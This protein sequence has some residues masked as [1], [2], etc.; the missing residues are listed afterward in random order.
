MH[1]V[2]IGSRLLFSRTLCV[3][4]GLFG[5][6]APQV[7]ADEVAIHKAI[8]A[9]FATEDLD[10]RERLVAQI[11]SDPD[12]DPANVSAYLHGAGL[13]KPLETGRHPLT[14][15]W[16]DRTTALVLRIPANYDPD[17]AY[18]LLY[19]LHGAGGTADWI[20]RYFEFVL[21]AQ[22]E[23]FVVAAPDGYQQTSFRMNRGVLPEHR[24]ALRLVR[25][26]AN[27]NSNRIYASGYSM[28]G[29][30]S[31][32]LAGSMPE[33]LAGV[34]P[35]AG[36]LNAPNERLKEVF[37]ENARATTLFA[38]WG[39]LDDKARGG[40][41][42]PTG[43]IA[44]SNQRTVTL[45]EE[46]GVTLSWHEFPNMGHGNVVPPANR[47][48]ALLSQEREVYPKSVEKRMT[49]VSDA[50]TAWVEGSNWKGHQLGTTRQLTL[51][52]LRSENPD[53]RDDQAAAV[54]R[55]VRSRM[56]RIQADLEGQ[57]VSVSRHK[58]Q[59]IIVW[60][61]LEMIDWSEPVTIRIARRTRFTGTLEPSLFV[62]LTEAARTW[63]FERL[64]WAGVIDRPRSKAERITGRTALPELIVIPPDPAAAP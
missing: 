59:T 22:I 43:G 32:T 3:A 40:K 55:A 52:M 57:R 38:V 5:V 2:R 46:L 37:L 20:L 39:R 56:G 34:M 41:R 10:V 8:R 23:N 44:G 64:R 48:A 61:G 62:C 13:F 53:S 50:Q 54:N 33:M 28:G 27:I 42:H 16:G 6:V 58:L 47:M 15:A 51:S 19:A 7:H 12:Y 18:P 60:F 49:T 1:R 30:T 9:F 63:D 4:L 29:H 24:A 21:G 36:S 45:A 14:V 31:W 35:I 11:E 17:R 25:Q 26:T